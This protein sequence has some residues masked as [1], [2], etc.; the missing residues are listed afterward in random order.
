MN[1]ENDLEDLELVEEEPE[2]ILV[3]EK[4]EKPDLVAEA[5]EMVLSIIGLN[6]FDRDLEQS[7]LKVVNE[8]FDSISENPAYH[9]D[10]FRIPDLNMKIWDAFHDYEQFVHDNKF[11]NIDLNEIAKIIRE[12]VVPKITENLWEMTTRL[13]QQS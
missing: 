12:Q 5:K 10:I 13:S 6:V 3:E 9:S 1:P 8:H 4:K 11:E 7:L 2:K